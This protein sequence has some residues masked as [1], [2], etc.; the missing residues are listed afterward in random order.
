MELIIIMEGWFKGFSFLCSSS[1][2]RTVLTSSKR[3]CPGNLSIGVGGRR[4][5]VYRGVELGPHFLETD[6]ELS[7]LAL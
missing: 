6:F 4:A 1:F 2:P 3:H 7:D 5:A